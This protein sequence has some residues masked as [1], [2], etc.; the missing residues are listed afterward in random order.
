MVVDELLSAAADPREF[1]EMVIG[2][3]EGKE[4]TKRRAIAKRTC[5]AAGKFSY[6]DLERAVN[7]AR[8]KNLL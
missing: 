2:E 5:V 4:A 1:A 7:A 3:T 6:D 8:D